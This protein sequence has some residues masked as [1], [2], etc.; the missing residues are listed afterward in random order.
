MLNDKDEVV[1]AQVLPSCYQAYYF[2][3]FEHMDLMISFLLYSYVSNQSW[4]T[5]NTN[6]VTKEISRAFSVPKPLTSWYFWTMAQ[7]VH[8]SF[9]LSLDKDVLLIF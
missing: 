3:P 5:E 4:Y 7:Q 8:Y 2:R 9:L 1:V 6:P